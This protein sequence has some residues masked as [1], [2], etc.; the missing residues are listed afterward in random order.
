MAENAGK[1]NDNTLGRL[2]DALFAELERLSA[3]DARDPDALQA[4]IS[5]A[6][7]IEGVSKTIVEN[8]KVIMDATIMRANLTHEVSTP[9]M[10]EG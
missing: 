1:G 9:R 4:E 5:R 3:V 8:A 2:N 6:K 7:S 10:L